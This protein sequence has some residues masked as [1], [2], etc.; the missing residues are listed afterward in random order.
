MIS[1]VRLCFDARWKFARLNFNASAEKS[2][3][4]PHNAF[5]RFVSTELKLRPVVK[6]S[7]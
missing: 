1:G 2:E 7:V 3:R 5:E 6:G 4:F